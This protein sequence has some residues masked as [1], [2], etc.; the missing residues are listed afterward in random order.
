MRPVPRSLLRRVLALLERASDVDVYGGQ[1]GG[2]PATMRQHVIATSRAE[3]AQ[4][5]VDLQPWV[6][7]EPAVTR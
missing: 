7:D 1:F 6:S 4:L 5:L 2:S 3:V